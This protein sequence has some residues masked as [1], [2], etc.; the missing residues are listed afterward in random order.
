M[1]NWADP[2]VKRA[3]DLWSTPSAAIFTHSEVRGGG[4]RMGT[5]WRNERKEQRVLVKETKH[6][7][8]AGSEALKSP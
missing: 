6:E 1:S 4:E 2:A 3:S 5:G 7:A 8:D